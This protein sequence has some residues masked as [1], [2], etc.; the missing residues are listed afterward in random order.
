VREE[1]ECGEEAAVTQADPEV[2]EAEE[3]EAE[4]NHRTSK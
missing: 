3:E 4:A 2:G 1:S